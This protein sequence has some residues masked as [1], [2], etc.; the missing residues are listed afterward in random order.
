MFDFDFNIDIP[1]I[2][3][4]FTIP[5]ADNGASKIVTLEAKF[6]KTYRQKK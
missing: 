5:M 3:I 6:V 2:D 1:E 4:E